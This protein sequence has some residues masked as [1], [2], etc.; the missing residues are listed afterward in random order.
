MKIRKD[1]I[2]Q[3]ELPSL[4]VH[5][6]IPSPYRKHL[7][8]RMAEVFPDAKFYFYSAMDAD[9]P[10]SDDLSDWK[11][12]WR[13]M[14]RNI[15]LGRFGSLSLDLL[16]ELRRAPIGTVHLVGSGLSVLDWGIMSLVGIFR[17][18]TVVHFSDAGFPD[19]L[20]RKT[21]R[22]WKYCFGLGC[23]YHFAPGR[24][25][26]DYG[27]AL[28]FNPEKIY[29][30]FF[31]HDVNRF[32]AYYQQHAVRA[33]QTLREQHGIPPTHHVVLTISRFL[34]WKRLE[35]AAA[36]LLR[37]ETEQPEL[38][39]NITY[40]LIGDGAWQE[41]LPILQQL[42]KTRVLLLP[43]MPYDKVLN[44]YCAADYFL[45][46][47]EGDIWGLVVN[48]ALSMHVPVICTQRIGAAEL[49]R[50]GQNGYVVAPRDPAGIAKCLAAALLDEQVWRQQKIE[51][52]AIIESWKSELGIQELIRLCREV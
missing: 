11:I 35:D 22:R 19:Q 34:D 42:C 28:G 21:K 20:T 12:E 25:G 30:A 1:Q 29:N 32:N 48:E 41:H 17:L 31:S 16:Q 39:V 5:T 47:S 7:F 33:R 6:N 40:V 26:R 13:R 18:A 38:A 50:N 15:S 2:E 14:R 36:A 46:P 23:R 24:L 45:F 52:N 49:V 3:V 9:R 37:L 27:L 4:R 51:A 10:W 8:E 44:W 43:Q